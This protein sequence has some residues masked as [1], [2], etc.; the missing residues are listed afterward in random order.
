[1]FRFLNHKQFNTHTHTNTSDKT[2][3]NK[4]SVC[5]NTQRTQ[6]TNIHALSGIRTRNPSYQ[7][8]RP[9]TPL[10]SLLYAFTARVCKLQKNLGPEIIST[11]K[12]IK[13]KTTKV[14]NNATKKVHSHGS[15]VHLISPAY[16]SRRG[17]RN[18]I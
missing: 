11:L 15:Q 5:H 8:A 1:M 9:H 12:Q 18:T 6:E 4:R 3:L 17:Y 16:F 10:N 7:T 14:S 2:P 13:L